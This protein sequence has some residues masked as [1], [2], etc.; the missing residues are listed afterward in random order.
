MGIGVVKNPRRVG[1]IQYFCIVLK[2]S[3]QVI[4]IVCR[5]MSSFMDSDSDPDYAPCRT[6]LPRKPTTPYDPSG[7]RSSVERP[8]AMSKCVTQRSSSAA[9]PAVQWTI[10]ASH[11]Q[12]KVPKEKQTHTRKLSLPFT[13]DGWIMG[14]NY[15]QLQYAGHGQS[16]TVY[17]LTD[18]LVLK[19]CEKPDQEPKL[20]KA[21]QATGVFP[22]VHAS[23]ECQ[24][25]DSAGGIFAQNWYAWVMDY[26]K[27]LDQVLQEY[28]A[29]SYFCILG[30]IHAMV[31]AHSSEHSLSDNALFN[32]GMVQDNVVIIDAGSRFATPPMTKG[33]FNKLIMHKFWSKAQTLVQPVDLAVHRKQWQ[34]APLDMQMVLQFY[35][36]RWHNLCK[37][38]HPLP[39]LDSL[40]VPNFTFS[41]CPHVASVLDT[42][43]DETLDWLTQTYLWDRSMDAYMLRDRSTDRPLGSISKY[44]P[45]D[46]GYM[47]RHLDR[48]WTAAEKL[49]QLISETVARRADHCA[50]PA[51][52]ILNEDKLKEILDG[53]KN[54]YQRWMRPET[55]DQTWRMSPQIWH[56]TLRK[57]FR[58]HLFHFVGSFE[59]VVFFIVAPFNNDH[60]QV[61]RHYTDEVAMEGVPVKERNGRILERSKGYA[62]ANT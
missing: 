40:E 18:K 34:S 52:D 16:K 56:Q 59:M 27:P 7:R 62:R 12:V 20:F 25:F 37:D 19:L 39:V 3:A 6:G 47:R 45:S 48:E 50:H 11:E 22:M 33:E 5:C 13:I 58:L 55:L 38:K 1:V 10:W 4:S 8:V 30:A 41:A 26:A 31:T 32:F 36:D 60:L 42:L 46:D 23:C 61:F 44:G 21:L 51:D 29:T 24:V 15:G 49:E 43:D 28:P 53:W 2:K 9:P 35:Q 17:R 14:K 57:V 54:D